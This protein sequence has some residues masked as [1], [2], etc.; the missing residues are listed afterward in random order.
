MEESSKNIDMYQETF[1]MIDNFKDDSIDKTKLTLIND[2]FLCAAYLIKSCNSINEN[3]RRKFWDLFN[4][5]TRE[6]R[7]MVANYVITYY[8]REALKNKERKKEKSYTK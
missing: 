4:D 1:K 2:E 8:E 3:Y 7:L 5:F 6:Q